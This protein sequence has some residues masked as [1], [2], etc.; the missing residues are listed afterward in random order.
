MVNIKKLKEYGFF[1]MSS[2]EQT[3]FLR[4]HKFFNLSNEYKIK[5]L[6]ETGLFYLDINDDPPNIP[7]KSENVDY[8]KTKPENAKKNQIS[9][10]WKEA[11]VNNAIKKRYIKNKFNKRNRKFKKSSNRSNYNC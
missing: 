5:F 6:E 11:F 10:V 7:L 4:K 9:N 8:L 2:N 1:N 3:E